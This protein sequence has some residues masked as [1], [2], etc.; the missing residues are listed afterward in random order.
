MII[1]AYEPHDRAA[2]IA[3]MDQLNRHED[4][5]AGDRATSF[6]A[7]EACVDREIEIER[8]GE[9][10]LLVADVDGVAVGLASFRI[11]RPTPY[12]RADVARVCWVSNL[13]VDEGRRGRGV[14]RALLLA[15]ETWAR[16]RGAGRL[17]IGAI[18]G[19]GGA[20]AAYEALGF[21]PS[22]IELK[23]DLSRSPSGGR[24]R[25]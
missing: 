21:T 13:V 7:A 15:G 8:E 12:L 2:A 6:E 3:L 22:V 24:T 14:G 17:S 10:V 1:R 5:I 9:G 16:R 11:D 18:I 20:I 4:A 19:N 25:T 23:K